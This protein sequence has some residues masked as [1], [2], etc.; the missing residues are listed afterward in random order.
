MKLNMWMIVNRLKNFDIEYSINSGMEMNLNSAQPVLIPDTVHVT[1][2]GRDVVCVSGEDRIVIHDMNFKD[3]Y[4]LVQSIFNWYQDWLIR[5][6]DCIMSGR[7]DEFATEMYSAFDN[8]VMFQDSNYRLLGMCHEF[9]EGDMPEEWKYTQDIGQSSVEG[10]SLMAEYLTKHRTV[11]YDNVI[12]FE[13]IKNSSVPYNGMFSSMRFHGRSFAKLIVLE[14]NR[15]FNQRDYG[16]FS[17]LA[18]RISIYSA[19]ISTTFD[20]SLDDQTLRRLL[21]GR[22]VQPEK[23]MFFHNI[24]SQEERGWFS[25]LV[26]QLT[27]PKKKNDPNALM[28]LDNLI[29]NRYTASTTCIYQDTIVILLCVP[30]PKDTASQ[31]LGSLESYGYKDSVC[32]GQSLN[33]TNLSETHFF[34]DQA[35]L[36]MRFY[37]KEKKE[38]HGFYDLA[39]RYLLSSGDNRKMYCEPMARKLWEQNPEKRDYLYSVLIYLYMERSSTKAAEKLFIHK[40]TLTYRIKVLREQCGW[41]FEDPYVRRYVSLSIYLLSNNDNFMSIFNKGVPLNLE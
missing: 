26:L 27:D 17:H 2:S 35:V 41:D 6:D 28:I 12:L 21:E 15:P 25:V 10:Y 32:A 34:Y 3:G 9:K 14:Y 11:S 37:D 16:L 22:S 19:A 18:R 1:E 30:V 5:V 36:S 23:M 38:I 24:M 8:P 39:Y 13:A 40:N 4:T 29:H 33:F 31:I 20:N 7:F